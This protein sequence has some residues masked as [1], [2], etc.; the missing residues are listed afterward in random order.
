VTSDHPGDQY[1]TE[2]H[3]GQHDEQKP[4]RPFTRHRPREK[5]NEH[6]LQIAQDRGR[7]GTDIRDGM[8][9]EHKIEC[10]E[11]SRQHCVAVI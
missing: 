1:D 11:E 5:R 9:P 7:S 6:D 3:Y 8:D 2:Q 4:A 10:Q